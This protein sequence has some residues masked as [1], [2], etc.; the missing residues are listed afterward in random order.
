VDNSA[1]S[2][3]TPAHLHHTGTAA[4]YSLTGRVT[5]GAWYTVE[6]PNLAGSD[7]LGSFE[8]AETVVVAPVV[9][10]RAVRT[11]GRA[12]RN[13]H[14]GAGES[15]VAANSN[16]VELGSRAPDFALPDV[17]DGETVTL[18]DLDGEVLV[19]VFLSNHC[20]YVKHTQDEIAAVARRYATSER[21][22][23]VGIA[24][25]DPE[26]EPDDA[27]E[28]LAEQ[29]EEVGFV[30]PYLFDESQEVAHAFGAACTPDVFVF[31][32]DR[33]LAY[34]GR[35]DETRPGCGTAADGSELRAAINALLEGQRP[36]DDQWPAIG[37]SIKWR[38]GNEPAPPG[39]EREPA[40]DGA[41]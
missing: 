8:G 27:P 36:D 20:P 32:G 13:H 29:K 12:D 34:R 31:D 18:D 37:C 7:E 22:S 38:P 21:V 35:L 16:M 11:S 40:G 1:S 4:G 3:D 6:A 33:A 15:D 24:S 23:F 41:A 10:R 19:V 9:E 39:D 25:N 28:R 26:R 17:A 14:T 2:G 5:Y 30:F